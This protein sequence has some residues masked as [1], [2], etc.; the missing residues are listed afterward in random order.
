MKNLFSLI[1]M[2]SVLFLASCSKSTDDP[3]PTVQTNLD[4]VKATLGGTWTFQSVKVTEI[5]TSK[6]ATTSICT[7]TELNASGLFTNKTWQIITPLPNFTY[8]STTSVNINYPCLVGSPT[9][10]ES[11]TLTENSDGTVNMTIS[12]QNSYKVNPSDITTTSI[13]ANLVNSNGYLIEYQFKR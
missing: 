10:T 7:K 13:K 5:S 11:I 4:K 1:L 8:V 6:S 2:V 3:T 12:N 9:S